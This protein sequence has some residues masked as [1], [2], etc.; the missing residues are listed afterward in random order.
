MAEWRKQQ[1]IVSVYLIRYESPRDE[2]AC[3]SQYRMSKLIVRKIKLDKVRI[4]VQG[5]NLWTSTKYSGL[6]PEVNTFNTSNT[7]LGTDFLT[8]P[9]PRT[10]TVGLNIGF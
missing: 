10:Y 1:C 8:F 6:D 2:T 9:Q 4:Y 7:A 3:L 5:A